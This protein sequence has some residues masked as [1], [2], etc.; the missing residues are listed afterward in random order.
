MNEC[1]ISF[2]RVKSLVWFSHMVS[3]LPRR[4][5]FSHLVP[6]P[7]TD[8]ISKAWGKT[9]P[10]TSRGGRRLPNSVRH[11]ELERRPR[12]YSSKNAR[13]SELMY[14]NLLMMYIQLWGLRQPETRSCTFFWEVWSL[15][16]CSCTREKALS[17]IRFRRKRQRQSSLEHSSTTIVP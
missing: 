9:S 7:G 16:S 12:S 1:D 14:L 5:W 6:K 15:C 13:L 4:A 8:A 10:L 11:S 3:S 2:R 17:N